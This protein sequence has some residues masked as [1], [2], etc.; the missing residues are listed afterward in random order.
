[1]PKPKAQNVAHTKEELFAGFKVIT[2]R[3]FATMERKNADYAGEGEW[4]ANFGLIEVLTKGE[5]TREMGT[6]VR[7]S[8]KL[9]RVVR[10]LGNANQ[11]GRVLDEKIEDTL[12]D[13]ANYSILMI[14]MLKEKQR[15]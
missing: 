12:L 15:G 3:M 11:E 10:L 9:S 7:M 4:S 13:L 6:I 8:D 5:I 1:M 14:L 2:E